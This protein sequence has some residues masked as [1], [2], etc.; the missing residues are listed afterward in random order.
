MNTMETG[1]CRLWSERISFMVNFAAGQAERE[2]FHTVMLYDKYL[3]LSKC[4]TIINDKITQESTCLKSRE[5]GHWRKRRQNP[6]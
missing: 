3:T 2:A 4:G 1:H 6:W 5:S